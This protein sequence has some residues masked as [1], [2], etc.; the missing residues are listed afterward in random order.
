M[1]RVITYLLSGHSSI[2]DY[3]K[4][5]LF[6]CCHRRHHYAPHN[7][8]IPYL[9]RLD[10]FVAPIIQYVTQPYHC[11]DNYCYYR[12]YVCDVRG[13]QHSRRFYGIKSQSPWKHRNTAF[14]NESTRYAEKVPLSFS[15]IPFDFAAFCQGYFQI[16]YWRREIIIRSYGQMFSIRFPVSR[17]ADD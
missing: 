4:F 5:F 6:R 3:A 14:N 2:Y 13:P 8:L 9:F 12:F 10:G 16:L 1:H 7:L 15:F 17:L 11:D